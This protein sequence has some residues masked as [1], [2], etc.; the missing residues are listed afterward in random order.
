[1]GRVVTVGI[2]SRHTEL[3]V[4]AIVKAELGLT[5]STIDVMVT[6]WV[7]QAS[8][9]VTSY[10]GR[11]FHREQV[12][13]YMV[14]DGT[15]TI[16]LTR[17]PVVSVDKVWDEGTTLS[18]TSW[19]IEDGEAGIVRAEN[20]W[21]NHR[22]YGVWLEASPITGRQFLKVRYTAGYVC[23]NDGSTLPRTLPHD[24]EWAVREIVKLRWSRRK[25]DPFVQRERIGESE[26]EYFDQISQSGMPPNV[27][28]ILDMYRSPF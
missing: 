21:P 22:R 26:I 24:I 19:V 7:Q 3:T 15:K 28:K 12:D 6:D 8:D 27:L 11:K 10:T 23:P 2:P 5:G 17:R 14:G 9:Y 25:T 1:M 16:L 18:S 4:P 13:E 20:G